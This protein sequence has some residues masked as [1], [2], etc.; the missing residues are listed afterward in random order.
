MRNAPATLIDGVHSALFQLTHPTCAAALL[1]VCPL[2]QV[3]SV[4]SR[5]SIKMGVKKGLAMWGVAGFLNVVVPLVWLHG[6]IFAACTLASAPYM[7]A[8]E[9]G[10]PAVRHP[11]LPFLSPPTARNLLFLNLICYEG[12]QIGVECIPAAKNGG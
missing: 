10:Y 5:A 3:D 8:R 2:S 4:A 12:L 9:L 1:T 7:P 6:G 11:I